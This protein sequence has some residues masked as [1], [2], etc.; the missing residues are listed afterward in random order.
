M[1]GGNFVCSGTLVQG[2]NDRAI[3]AT[4]A[5]CLYDSDTHSFAYNVLVI[6]AQDDGSGEGSDRDCSNDPNGCFY[7]TFAAV[8]KHYKTATFQNS[9]EYDYGFYVAPDTDPGPN[10]GPHVHGFDNGGHESIKPMAISFSGVQ[11]GFETHLFGYPAKLDPYFMYSIGEAEASPLGN[12]GPYVDCSGLTGGA[13][14]RPW[15]QAD[16]SSG[17]LVVH[18]VN[19]WGWGNGNPGMGAPPFNTGGAQC[20]FQAANT[21]SMNSGDIVA[22]HCPR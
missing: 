8:S 21:A 20:L 2:Q 7:P 10:N 3:I 14:G 9:F 4:A 15:T 1:N 13:S 5:H 12:N 22:H 6:P 19:S 16:T 17:T 18:S 11:E